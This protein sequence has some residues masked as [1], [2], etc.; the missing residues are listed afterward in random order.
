[1]PRRADALRGSSV[2]GVARRLAGADPIFLEPFSVARRLVLA[3]ELC[4]F[5][6][7]G[8]P[9]AGFRGLR[10]NIVLMRLLPWNDSGSHSRTS[11]GRPPTVDLTVVRI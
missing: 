1:M 8:F 3:A 11:P 6:Q 7:I 9:C 4:G 5:V 10:A 2:Y